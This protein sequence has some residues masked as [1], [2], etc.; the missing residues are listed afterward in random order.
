MGN[1]SD[2]FDKSRRELLET[3]ALGLKHLDDAK[4]HLITHNCDLI[5]DSVT[6]LM[7]QQECS[8]E[9]AAYLFYLDALKTQQ[10][11]KLFEMGEEVRFHDDWTQKEA[12]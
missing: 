4:H 7:L 6:H 12:S 10:Q 5:I 1:D 3:T 2:T 9:Q 8:I 11:A